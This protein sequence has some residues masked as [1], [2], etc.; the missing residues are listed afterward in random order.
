MQSTI[1]NDDKT[2][3][4]PPIDHN[5]GW[6]PRHQQKRTIVEKK[7]AEEPEQAEEAHTP[8]PL[9]FGKIDIFA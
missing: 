6:R 9:P 1:M 4:L 7:P 2:E 5:Q 8:Q 3:T